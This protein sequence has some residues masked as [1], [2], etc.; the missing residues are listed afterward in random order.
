MREEKKAFVSLCSVFFF[1]LFC[2]RIFPSSWRLCTYKA[3]RLGRSPTASPSRPDVAY[4]KKRLTGGKGGMYGQHPYKQDM[5]EHI[6]GRQ[7]QG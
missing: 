1:P 7:Q 4:P 6:S 2:C 3:E 5:I